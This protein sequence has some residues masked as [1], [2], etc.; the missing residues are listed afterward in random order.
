MSHA[1]VCAWI[2]DP[3]GRYLYVNPM[4]RNLP[5]YDEQCLG[6]T[7]A[8]ILP[9]SIAQQYQQNDRK[10]IESR[11]VLQIVEQFVS[12][13][14]TKQMLV[15]KFPILDGTGEVVMVAG[16]SV[17][18]T[19]LIEA[20]RALHENQERLRLALAATNTGVWTWKPATGKIYWS[21]EC[22]T[23]F[24]TRPEDFVDQADWFYRR[25][26]PEDIDLV[27]QKVDSALHDGS[28]YVA[29]FRII[30][31]SGTVRWIS[32]MGQAQLDEEGKP[33]LMLGIVQDI[34]DRRRVEDELAHSRE[35]LRAL[36]ARLEAVREA[37]RKSISRRVH[38]E[39]GQLLSGLKMDLRW[40]EKNASRPSPTALH[41]QLV[42]KLAGA[43]Q[44]VDDTIKT[45]QLIAVELRPSALDD[46]GLVDAIG[47]EVRRFS[48]RSGI[49]VHLELPDSPVRFPPN[50]T[51][52]L[53][54]ILQELLTNVARHSKA[55]LVRVHLGVHEDHVRLFVED[56]GVGFELGPSHPVLALGLLGM[57][58]RA[59]A[60]Q[61]EFKMTSSP[62]SGTSATVQVPLHTPTPSFPC[63][64]S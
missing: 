26:H 4:V 5:G 43:I 8:E 31:P 35:Q 19:P 6:K 11:E 62:G 17:D 53:F 24:G 33:W 37:E 61:G 12:E 27:R 13:G 47:E 38:D 29:E 36:A 40:I 32:N 3:E 46:L 18:G 34:T 9:P 52:G 57:S 7:D 10:V 55:N 39:L 54:R 41:P 30:Q 42:D 56:D 23:I 14:V 21:P 45:I 44:I 63:P 1:L 15:S 51:I 28:A 22:H 64:R 25:V 58:E 16:C 20:E 49:R 60:M 2:K 48:D 50:I 59:T